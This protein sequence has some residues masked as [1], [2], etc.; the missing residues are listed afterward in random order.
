MFSYVKKF[1]NNVKCIDYK[2]MITS[3]QMWYLTQVL[4]A[5]VSRA[6][7]TIYLHLPPDLR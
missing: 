5:E 7:L 2:D 3:W 1:R 4:V 6:Y